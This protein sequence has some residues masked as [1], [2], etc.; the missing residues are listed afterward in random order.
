MGEVILRVLQINSVYNS[1]STGKIVK[2]I[3]E[4]LMR[5]GHEAYVCYGRG[6]SNKEAKCYKTCSKLELYCNVVFTRLSGLV[7]IGSPFATKR[8]IKIID[9]IKP[10]IIHLHN[11]HG[12]YVNIIKLIKHIQIMGIPVVWT[13]HDEFMFTGRCAVTGDCNSWHNSCGKCKELA[14][15]PKTMFFDFSKQAYRLKKN[16]VAAFEKVFFVMPSIW[17]SNKYKVSMLSRFPWEI[18]NNGIDIKNIFRPVPNWKVSK[19]KERLGLKDEKIILSVV[20]K[21]AATNKGGSYIIDLAEMFKG[22]RSI[23]IIIVGYSGNKDVLPDN[24]LP[25]A[26]TR[27]QKELAEYYSMADVFAITSKS[28]NFPTVCLEALACGTPVIGFNVGGTAE[29]AVGDCGNFVDFGDLLKLQDAAIYMIYNKEKITQKCRVMAEEKYS[30]IKM[31]C[32]YI[33][34]YEKINGR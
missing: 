25:I 18:I 31:A 10:D 15:Y 5:S 20:P 26:Y 6:E 7:G 28:E 8:M 17:M 21:F 32:S 29:T 16:V 14:A 12:Y 34:L 2:A 27:D 4:Q 1:G 30:D 23:K 24:I 13:L 9:E 19:L 22:D 11:L 33:K 3:Q